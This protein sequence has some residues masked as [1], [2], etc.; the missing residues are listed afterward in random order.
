M[1]LPTF[2]GRALHSRGSVDSCRASWAPA[3]SCRRR[4]CPSRHNVV[5]CSAVATGPSSREA[6]QGTPPKQHAGSNGANGSVARNARPAPPKDA[7]VPDDFVLAPGEVSHVDRV[8]SPPPGEVFRCP[9]CTEPACQGPKGCAPTQWRFEP[10]G[11]L[12]Q[13]L[14]ARV[15]DVAVRAPTCPSPANP[16]PWRG[17]LCHRQ[18]LRR[19]ALM[20]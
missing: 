6:V 8:S 7:Y 10:D 17:A 14:T 18:A 15:Y 13:I 5:P 12:R 9:G 2:S 20:P 11:Y 4:L 1:E 3:S 16:N 19:L